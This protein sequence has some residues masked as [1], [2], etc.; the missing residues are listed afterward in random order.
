MNTPELANIP[1]HEE[2][3]FF[4]PL[5]DST[6][7]LLNAIEK[8]KDNPIK[9]DL[10]CFYVPSRGKQRPW[11]ELYLIREEW[12]S[13]RLYLMGKSPML[14]FYEP[15]MRGLVN[16]DAALWVF[17]KF[18]Q[19]QQLCFREQIKLHELSQKAVKKI[20]FQNIEH[21]FQSELSNILH[22]ESKVYSLR[23][24]ECEKYLR[25]ANH[26]LPKRQ[27]ME[28]HHLA[29]I[30]L[31]VGLHHE[32][33]ELV[34]MLSDKV[35]TDMQKLKKRMR[36]VHTLSMKYYFARATDEQKR[37]LDSLVGRD[38]GNQLQALKYLE[39]IVSRSFNIGRE[40]QQMEARNRSQP[41]K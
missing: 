41:G 7:K 35:L 29:R 18:E 16:K 17:P 11:N 20:P 10:E 13:M 14:Y 1:V 36:A 40:K 21:H 9:D 22:D 8:A 12:Q 39:R 28:V 24:Q 15:P 2:I 5:L 4:H 25:L 30:L 38:K 33:V 37:K 31:K 34:R 19:V 32:I 6:R 3:S 27:A 26:Y 23:A